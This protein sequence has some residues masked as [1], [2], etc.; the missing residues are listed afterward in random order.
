M[1]FPFPVDPFFVKEPLTPDVPA[2]ARLRGRGLASSDLRPA[3]DPPWMSH[4]TGAL[5]SVGALQPDLHR[6]G[7]R[8]RA[9]DDP[10]EAAHP[11]EP[12]TERLARISGT[13]AASVESIEG[14]ESTSP[15]SRAVR[16]GGVT[17]G[18]DAHRDAGL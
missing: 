6:D 10:A 15:T 18:V 2:V 14:S 3:V 13:E 5:G 4:E 9:S 7:P 12:R 11:N 16:G 1:A 8:A 17:R